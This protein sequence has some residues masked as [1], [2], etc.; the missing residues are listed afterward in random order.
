MKSKILHTIYIYCLILLSACIKPSSNSRH[1]KSPGYIFMYGN[2]SEIKT[3]SSY[4]QDRTVLL[5]IHTTYYTGAEDYLLSGDQRYYDLCVKYGD[6]KP[7]GQNC[8]V[9]YGGFFGS[10]AVAI[11]EAIDAIHIT[12]SED[13]DSEHTAGTLLDDIFFVEYDSY[14]RY[15]RNNYTGEPVEH[16]SK[17]LADIRPGD[18]YLA[19]K[20]SV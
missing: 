2:L 1:Y 10:G 4:I 11:A 19:N 12:S 7:G 20:I 14:Y 15:I 5:Y 17:P 13:W 8:H 9:E 18:M 6:L 16:C 3:Y